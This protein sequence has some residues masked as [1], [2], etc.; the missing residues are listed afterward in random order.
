VKVKI[1]L[2]IYININIE[3]FLG[4]GDTF[5]RTATLQHCSAPRKKFENSRDLF[6][7]R[8]PDVV[9]LHCRN[10]RKN[11]ALVTEKIFPS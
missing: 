6:V 1:K 2:Y 3:V 9:P 8:T 4:G 5:S 10:E 7:D 11:S